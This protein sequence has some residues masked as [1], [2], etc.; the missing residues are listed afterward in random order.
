MTLPVP[1]CQAKENMGEA[2]EEV[3]EI[4]TVERQVGLKEGRNVGGWTDDGSVSQLT[5]S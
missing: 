3:E 2:G 5:V 1:Q 4:Y